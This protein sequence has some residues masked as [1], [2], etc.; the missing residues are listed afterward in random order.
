[1]QPSRLL[2]LTLDGIAQGGAGVG[3][4]DDL[5]VFASGGLPGE[6]VRMRGPARFVFDVIPSARLLGASAR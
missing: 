5:V 4:A 1:M 3:R 6:R 2:E